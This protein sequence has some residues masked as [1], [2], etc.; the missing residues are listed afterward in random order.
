MKLW[1]VALAV[2]VTRVWGFSF[3]AI[4]IGVNN[5]P[6][7]LFSALRFTLATDPLVFFL[8]PPQSVLDADL[9]HWFRS[10][11]CEIL[12]AVHRDGYEIVRRSCILALAIRSFYP[13]FW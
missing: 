5:F 1:E 9:G 4:Q 7:L 13:V 3:V 8:P 12:A 11:C 10:W 2:L 6:P